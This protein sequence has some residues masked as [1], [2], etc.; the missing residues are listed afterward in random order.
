[1]PD[2]KVISVDSHVQE[3]Q[4]LYQERVP[5]KY[6]DRLPRV[7]ERGDGTYSI[8]EERKPRRLDIAQTRE[9]EE[10]QLRQFR[11]DESGGNAVSI[12]LQPDNISEYHGVT[13]RSESRP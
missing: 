3:S 1:M 2:Q 8:I 12:H 4:T 10:D 6:H 11:N 13:G 5:A 9:T 7:E